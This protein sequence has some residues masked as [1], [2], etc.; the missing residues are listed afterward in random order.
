M[1]L[2]DV[3]SKIEEICKDLDIN[4]VEV[5]YKQLIANGLSERQLL[6][7]CKRFCHP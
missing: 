1:E 3:V 4:P 2:K 7:D 5:T 6:T